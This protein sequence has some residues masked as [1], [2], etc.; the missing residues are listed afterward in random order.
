MNRLLPF[1]WIAAARFLYEG[2]VQSALIVAGVAIGVSVIVFMS[3]LL[4]GV[5]GNVVR[6][7]LTAQAHI[8][9]LP[10]EELA[11]PLRNEPGRTAVATIQRQA[12]R[13]RSID[14]WQTVVEQTR[15]TPGVVAVSPVAAGPA[16]AIRGDATKQVTLYGVDPAHHFR[17]VRLDEKIIAGGTA[18]TGGDILIGTELAAD[19][20]LALGDKLRIATTGGLAATLRVVGIF[21]LGN[22]AAN[23]RN[24]YVAL[25]TAQPLLGLTGGV[26]NIDI[27]LADLY[28]AET[29][30]RSIA[31]RTG[32]EADSWIKTNAQFFTAMNAQTLSSMII[33]L[34]VALSVAFGIA[35]VL[36]V[37]VVQRSKEIGI[38]RAMGTSRGQ[39]LRVFLIQGGIVGLSGSVLGAAMGAGFVGIWR[40]AALNPD[41]TPLFAI[42]LDP[43]LFIAAAVIAT[44]SGVLAA[45]TPALRAARLDPVVAIRG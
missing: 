36:V 37:S 44:L 45:I 34:S 20:G 23:Q 16:Y 5:Q 28:A 40:T 9:V 42:T 39:I 4:T 43:W 15:A 26:S 7:T 13:L 25:R 14:Q 22:K 27:A 31:A 24:T 6:R 19:L 3:A 11:R 32:L 30:A 1:E 10:R 17:V 33:R 29:V 8:V 41:G 21:D 35:S 12:Q 2:R 18:L 38:L